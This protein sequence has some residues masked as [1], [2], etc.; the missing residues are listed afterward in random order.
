MTGS[1]RDGVQMHAFSSQAN[2]DFLPTGFELR[3][4]AL[5]AEPQRWVPLS[6]SE[7][8]LVAMTLR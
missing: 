7:C 6:R 3:S 2:R 4:V 5:A 8:L 1:I